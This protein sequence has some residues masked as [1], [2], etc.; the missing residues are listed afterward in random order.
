MTLNRL[1]RLGLVLL[2]ALPVAAQAQEERPP[3]PE[4]NPL[5]AL[6]K[7]P[8]ASALPGDTPTVAWTEAE[9]A[10]AKAK[11]VKLLAAL[12]IDYEPLPPLKEGKCGAPAPIRLKALGS[13]PKVK[14]EPPATVTCA[15]AAGLS[16]W[17]DK[18]VQPAA[19]ASLGVPVIRLSNASSYVCRNRYNGTDTPISEHALA[20][21]LD[22]SEFVFQS[23][24]KVT[25]LASWPGVVSGPPVPKPNPDRVV[26]PAEITGSIT[27]AVQA[28]AKTVDRAD[29]AN[30]T[31]TIAKSS[32][33][34]VRPKADAR[35]NP[36]VLPAVAPKLPPPKPP[37]EATPPETQSASERKGEFITKVHRDACSSFGTVL[38]PNAN[39]A[40]K[41]HFHLDMKARLRRALCE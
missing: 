22:I 11:C 20:N 5:R 13:D 18:T 39:D 10:K 26:A 21:A 37:A 3:L 24:E 8:A 17:L 36:F 19:R 38:G 33:P 28:K 6:A 29:V 14:I 7:A 32:N 23:G 9:V 16:A 2:V 30:A 25:V 34:F 4:R 40:H 12:A 31:T 15:V 1:A 27:P 35:T 41:D